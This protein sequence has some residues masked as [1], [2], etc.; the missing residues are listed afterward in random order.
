MF[1]VGT[2]YRLVLHEG[3]EKR[4]DYVKMPAHK[5]GFLRKQG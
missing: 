5:L 2:V 3:I 1:V 4:G